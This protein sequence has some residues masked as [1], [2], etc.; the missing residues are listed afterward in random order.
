MKIEPNMD[1][2]QLAERMG[3]SATIDDAT[4][5]RDLLVDAHKGEDTADVP[6]SVWLLLLNRAIK[7]PVGT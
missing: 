2:W 1:L 3:S 6:E 7:W 4:A 5:M